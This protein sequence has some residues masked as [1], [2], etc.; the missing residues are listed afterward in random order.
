MEVALKLL[1]YFI[2]AMYD[3]PVMVGVRRPFTSH[4]LLMDPTSSSCPPP[5]NAD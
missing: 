2:D 5:V 4:A 1:L 3:L